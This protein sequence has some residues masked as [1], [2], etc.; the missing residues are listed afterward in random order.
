MERM[1]RATPNGDVR[2]SPEAFY[3]ITYEEQYEISLMK[4]GREK[5]EAS[6]RFAD[7]CT[8]C[9]EWHTAYLFYSSVLEKVVVDKKIVEQYSDFADWAYQGL[10]SCNGSDDE[11]TWECSS[12]SLDYYREIFEPEDE[13]KREQR[14]TEQCS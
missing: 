8:S 7:L 2:M 14:I 10:I 1:V 4:D 6:L 13:K 5:F 12:N 3:E 11:Y 9:N